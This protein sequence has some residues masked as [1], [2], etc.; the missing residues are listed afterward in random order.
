MIHLLFILYSGC[1]LQALLASAAKQELFSV[2][3][4]MLIKEMHAKR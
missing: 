2:L 4:I 1:Q 3:L